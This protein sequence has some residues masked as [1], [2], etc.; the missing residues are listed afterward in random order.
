[1][2]AQAR[3][4]ANGRSRWEDSATDATKYGA[5]P[6][7]R[8]VQERFSQR[9]SQGNCTSSV[10]MAWAVVSR[11]KRVGLTAGTLAAWFYVAVRAN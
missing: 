3:R 8:A 2:H 10:A 9:H 1:M 7:A 5:A 11:D 6:P 4:A